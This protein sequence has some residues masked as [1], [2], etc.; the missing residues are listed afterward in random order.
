[1][2]DLKSELGGRFEDAIVAL[3]FTPAEFDA[4]ELRRAMRGAGTDEAALI[5]ILCTR[6]NAQIHALTAAYKTCKSNI[7]FLL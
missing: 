6:S 7:D 1:M 2:H 4:M 3:M 5:E